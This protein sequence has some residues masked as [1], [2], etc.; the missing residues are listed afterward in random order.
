MYR[1]KFDLAYS[2]LIFAGEISIRDD[3]IDPATYF[4]C[5]RDKCN[6]TMR[7][8]DVDIVAINHAHEICNLVLSAQKVWISRIW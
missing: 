8:Y 7:T 2:R 3:I 6:S 1:K 4:I 5:M